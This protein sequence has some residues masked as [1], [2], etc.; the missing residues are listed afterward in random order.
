MMLLTPDVLGKLKINSTKLLSDF[1]YLKVPYFD[2]KVI[3]LR[4]ITPCD[5]VTASREGFYIDESGNK[6]HAE[7]FRQIACIMLSCNELAGEKAYLEKIPFGIVQQIYSE[8]IDYSGFNGKLET[9]LKDELE[10]KKK[11]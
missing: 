10:Q 6:I 7:P 8:I 5:L 9:I 2:D 1:R 11:P 3:S 4:K